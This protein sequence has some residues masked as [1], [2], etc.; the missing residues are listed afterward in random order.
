MSQSTTVS[1]ISASA[2]VG[3]T[4][5]DTF[6]EGALWTTSVDRVS[7]SHRR[8]ELTVLDYFVGRL[9]LY[10][11]DK[12]GKGKAIQKNH[13]TSLGFVYFGCCHDGKK[14]R[15]ASECPFFINVKLLPSNRLLISKCHM[16]HNEVVCGGEYRLRRT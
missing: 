5:D 4:S 2:P 8:E 15:K 16:E 12:Y 7:T 3:H 10:E 9:L 13:H 1:S 6:V 14:S 11:S